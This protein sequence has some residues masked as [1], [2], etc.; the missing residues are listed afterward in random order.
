MMKLPKEQAEKARQDLTFIAKQCEKLAMVCET[1][2]SRINAQQFK[3]L[4]AA[5]ASV[6]KFLNHQSWKL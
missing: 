4:N 6:E 5:L 1:G 3:E 2:G